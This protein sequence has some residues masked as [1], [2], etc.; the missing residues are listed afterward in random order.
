VSPTATLPH[1]SF[2]TSNLEHATVSDAMH[3]GI[4]TCPTHAALT[5]VARLIATHHV[6]RVAVIGPAHA[7][8]GERLVWGVISDI[9]LVRA[10][11]PTRADRSAADLVSEPIIGVEPTVTLREAG[12][13]MLNRNTSH[14]VVIDPA[15]QRPI[16]VLS[17][18]DIVG[19]LAWG[20]D[21]RPQRHRR[22]T[23]IG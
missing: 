5:D 20:Q 4:V 11:I 18:L 7:Y 23:Q 10:A 16:G 9:D 13:L 1:G 12:A 6:H 8:N 19:I 14:L 17:A 2:L 21:S 22:V 15:T 3:P